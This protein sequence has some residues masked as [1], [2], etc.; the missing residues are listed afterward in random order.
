MPMHPWHFDMSIGP[1]WHSDVEYMPRLSPRLRS[2]YSNH[3][4][5]RAVFLLAPASKHGGRSKHVRGNREIRNAVTVESFIL[6]LKSSANGC[7]NQTG[8]LCTK[9]EE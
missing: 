5:F 3:V 4:T 1:D 2:N 6:D 8:K 7:S 9:L